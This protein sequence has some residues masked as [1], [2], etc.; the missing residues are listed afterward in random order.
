[1]CV[2]VHQKNIRILVTVVGKH[3]KYS[4]NMFYYA[5]YVDKKGDS[6]TRDTFFLNVIS[7]TWI[8]S[9]KYTLRNSPWHSRGS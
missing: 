4:R 5:R 1:M 9:I 2:S 3:L 7:W 8:L 6:R